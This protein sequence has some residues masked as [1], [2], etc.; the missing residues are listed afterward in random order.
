MLPR[1]HGRSRSGTAG[2]RIYREEIQGHHA[3]GGARKAGLRQ[4]HRCSRTSRHER[5]AYVLIQ[6]HI[7]NLLLP[8]HEVT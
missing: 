2:T 3:G 8:S 4:Y 6:P 5:C 7:N 1:I